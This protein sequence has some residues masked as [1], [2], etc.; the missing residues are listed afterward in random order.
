MFLGEVLEMI[1]ELIVQ[2][3]V[4]ARWKHDC[5]SSVTGVDNQGE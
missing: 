1:A 3:V 2:I 5:S 4:Y